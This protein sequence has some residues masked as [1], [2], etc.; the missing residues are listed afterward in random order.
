MI[1]LPTLA[2]ATAA[3]YHVSPTGSD[4]NPGTV[5]RPFA[6]IQKAAEVMV[7]GDTCFIGAGTYRETV[8]P[9]NNGSEGAPIVFK[10][11]AGQQVIIDGTD[12]VRGWKR[13]KGDVYEAKMTWDLGPNNELFFDGRMVDEARWPNNRDGDLLTPNAAKIGSGSDPNSI[14]CAR[15]PE[16]WAADSLRGAVAWAMAQSK[17]SSWTAPVIGYDPARKKVLLDGHK[18]WWVERRHNPAKGGTFYLVGAMCLLDSE[19]EWYYDSDTRTICL[20]PPDGLDANEHDVAAKRRLLAFDLRDRQYIHLIGV[21]LHAATIDLTNARHCLVK[22]IRAKFI[23]HTRGGKTVSRPGGKAGIEVSGRHN[24]IRDSEI[25]FSAGSGVVLRGRNN[26]VINC[27]IHHTDY[28]GSYAAP[29]SLWGLAHLVSHNTIHDTGRDCIKLGGAEHLIQYNDIFRPGRLCRDLGAIYSGGLDGGN[30]VI[31]YNWVHDN[32]GAASNVGIY[33]DNYMKNYI[34]HHNVVWNTGNSIRLNRPTGYCM[35]LHNTLFEDV[36]NSW[37]PWKGQYV[38]FGTHVL[39]NITGGPIRANPEVPQAGNIRVGSP[40]TCFDSRLKRPGANCPGVDMGVP[41]AG[42]NDEFKGKAPDAGAYEK[43]WRAWRAGHDF[44]DPPDAKYEKTRSVLRNYLR[45]AAFEYSRYA[46]G[47]TS[48]ALSDWAKTHGKHARVEFHRGFNTPPADARNSINANSAV[49]GSMEDD[50]IEQRVTGLRPATTYIF[51][52]YVKYKD[53]REVELGVK[54][55][56]GRTVRAIASEVNLHKGQTWR[57]IRVKFTTGKQSREA[58]VYI[59][60][61]G[62][63]TAYVDDTGVVPVMISAGP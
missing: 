63:G 62:A 38:Q 46:E 44:S 43:G 50:G 6:T 16:S 51:A 13:H 15:F 52:A 17:W 35:I 25:A 26:A 55:F 53:A 47:E 2:A 54:D 7:A 42:I 21:R 61:K 1:F 29:I 58:T 36:S 39:N 33:L 22:G 3:E 57:H 31:R 27:H 37:G 59:L 20:W 34:V 32:P 41:I 48:N 5:K 49:L 19:N 45:N 8:R 28:L 24:T 9:K 40:A 12:P 4:D 56:G 18:G 14:S 23:I 60:K 11:D 10:A 30:T